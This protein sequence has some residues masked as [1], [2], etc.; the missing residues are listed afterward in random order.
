MFAQQNVNCL[1][2]IDD[3]CLHFVACLFKAL[4]HLIFSE[5]KVIVHF[6]ETF[7]D[8]KDVLMIHYAKIE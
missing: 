3:S 4:H 7:G 6:F 8:M 1:V 2:N 5:V